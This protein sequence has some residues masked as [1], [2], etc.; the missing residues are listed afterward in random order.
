MYDSKEIELISPCGM[1][2]SICANY[3]TMK[4]QLRNK[5]VKMA[6]CQGCRPRNKNCAF[7]KKHCTKLSMKILDFCFECEYFPC[8][9]LKKLDEKYKSRYKMSMI[10]NLDLIKVK[11]VE[12]FYSSQ[13]KEWK[14]K[15]C[16]EMISCHNGLCFKCDLEELINKKKKYQWNKINSSIHQEK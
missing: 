1:N 6:Y 15:K 2:C 11:G 5:G 3:L 9:R 14:C 7:I 4:H 13:K 8:L 10:E 12:N 16:N